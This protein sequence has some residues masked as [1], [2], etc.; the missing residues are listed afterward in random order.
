MIE[1]KKKSLELGI[2][3]RKG[4]FFMPKEEGGLNKPKRERKK[5]ICKE[6]GKEVGNLAAH[7]RS[8]KMTLIDYLEKHD[9]YEFWMREIVNFLDKFYIEGCYRKLFLQYDMNSGQAYT[10][11]IA[12]NIKHNENQIVKH[13]E[14]DLAQMQLKRKY[15]LNTGDIRKHVEG[16]IAYGVKFRPTSSKLIG[17]DIDVRNTEVLRAIHDR[18]IISIHAPM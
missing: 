3:K 15:P 8:H 18:L 11:S 5:V 9:T 13:Y 4:Y 17:L 7:L 10:I 12:D 1:K 14:G 16:K 2:Q 6:C